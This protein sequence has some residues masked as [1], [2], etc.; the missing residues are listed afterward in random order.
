M[1]LRRIAFIGCEKKENDDVVCDEET[2]HCSIPS[3]GTLTRA[4]PERDGQAAGQEDAQKAMD[5]WQTR[6]RYPSPW[7]GKRVAGERIHLPRLPDPGVVHAEKHPQHHPPDEVKFTIFTV[8][9][10]T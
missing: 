9:V 2:C 1:C 6:G 5:E 3:R 4:A 8:L 7:S 10:H